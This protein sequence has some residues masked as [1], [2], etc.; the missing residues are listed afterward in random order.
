VGRG[1]RDH[2][3]AHVRRLQTSPRPAGQARRPDVLEQSRGHRDQAARTRFRIR[4]REAVPDLQSALSLCTAPGPAVAVVLASAVAVVLASAVAVVLGSAVEI[5]LVLASAV[6]VALIFASAVEVIFASA[7]E[8][9][10]VPASGV[11]LSA[12]N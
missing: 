11:I 2:R 5:V 4:H 1:G 12:A 3:A 6:E 9:V 7:V 8:V 10:L